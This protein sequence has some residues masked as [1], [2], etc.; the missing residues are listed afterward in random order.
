M[1]ELETR[2]IRGIV[3][4]ESYGNKIKSVLVISYVERKP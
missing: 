1:A 4:G 3:R 2:K